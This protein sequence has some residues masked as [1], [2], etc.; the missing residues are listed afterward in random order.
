MKSPTLSNRI[1]V[2]DNYHLIIHKYTNTHTHTHTHTHTDT[3]RDR[4]TETERDRER[5]E[6]ERNAS[7]NSC[8]LLP[9]IL[10]LL[11]CCKHVYS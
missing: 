3:D 7:P 9:Y 5:E 6:R 8:T 4:E 1:S 10:S 11:K 2:I